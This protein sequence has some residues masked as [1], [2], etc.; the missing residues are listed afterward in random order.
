M[1][2]IYTMQMLNKENWS[3]LQISEKIDWNKMDYYS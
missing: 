1:E 2:K 3:S